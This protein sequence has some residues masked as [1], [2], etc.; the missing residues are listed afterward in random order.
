MRGEQVSSTPCA[1]GGMRGCIRSAGHDP[2][3]HIA[4]LPHFDLRLPDPRTPRLQMRQTSRAR[5]GP[6]GSCACIQ[7]TL[8]AKTFA[9]VSWTR[10]QLCAQH[11]KVSSKWIMWNHGLM[12]RHSGMAGAGL[13]GVVLTWV[14]PT[15]L[16]DLLAA[17]LA[18]LAGY[19]ALLNLPLKR[20][21]AKNKLQ[22]V[23]DQFLQVGKGSWFPHLQNSHANMNCCAVC[24]HQSWLDH[25]PAPCASVMLCHK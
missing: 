12:G 25:G 15:T 1:W 6:S 14:L 23:A 3:G 7:T 13:F 20:A 10:A 8:A 22:R 4:A 2:A 19:V 5:E 17:S 16:E 9:A 21:E 18:G 24:V 11:C